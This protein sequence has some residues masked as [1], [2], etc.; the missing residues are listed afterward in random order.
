MNGYERPVIQSPMHEDATMHF[1]NPSF[2][3]TT[4]SVPCVHAEPIFDCPSDD[5]P[6]AAMHLASINRD[7][8]KNKKLHGCLYEKPAGDVRT[9]IRQL[10]KPEI[11]KIKRHDIRYSI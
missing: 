3:S 5:C 2:F 11:K 10:K 7:L 1:T 9:L 6:P 4:A 8:W